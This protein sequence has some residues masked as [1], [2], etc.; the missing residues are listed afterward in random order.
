MQNM[1]QGNVQIT[2]AQLASKF[3]SKREIWKWLS[4]EIRCYLDN[5]ESMTIWQ[6]Q[7]R[8]IIV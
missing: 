8:N 4:T 6:V 3:Q 5:Y 1:P 2:A 7:N